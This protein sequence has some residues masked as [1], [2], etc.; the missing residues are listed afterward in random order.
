L[1][2]LI[3]NAHA[4]EEEVS[5]VVANASV[6]EALYITVKGKAFASSTEQWKLITAGALESFQFDLIYRFEII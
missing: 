1:K 6:Y 3:E 2:L 4:F 5:S